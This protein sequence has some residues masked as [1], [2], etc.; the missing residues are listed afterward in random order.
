MRR[1]REVYLFGFTQNQKEKNNI[2]ES[3]RE[4]QAIWSVVNYIEI[5]EKIPDEA[6]FNKEFNFK[7]RIKSK[8]TGKKFSI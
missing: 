8:I 2:D 7:S 4:I 6:I 1:R 5:T 3:V